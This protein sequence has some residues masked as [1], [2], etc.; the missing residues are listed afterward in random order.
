[1]GKEKYKINFIWRR[2]GEAIADSLIFW[3]VI[4]SAVHIIS[5]QVSRLFGINPSALP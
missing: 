1:M 3:V 4:T 2:I 5:S